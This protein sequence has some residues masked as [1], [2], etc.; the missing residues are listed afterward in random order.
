MRPNPIKFPLKIA[1]DRDPDGHA[2]VAD[3]NNAVVIRL[4]AGDLEILN[5][6]VDELNARANKLN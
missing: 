1:E 3:A 2:R 5:V 6:I 4:V